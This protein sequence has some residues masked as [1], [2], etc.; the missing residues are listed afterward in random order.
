MKLTE[1]FENLIKEALLLENYNVL[2]D[3]F[4][5]SP[6]YEKMS[7]NRQVVLTVQ[8]AKRKL[9]PKIEDIVDAYMEIVRRNLPTDSASEEAYPRWRDA[10]FWIKGIRNRPILLADFIR[11]VIG[12]IDEIEVRE[13]RKK[14]EKDY[15]V[16]LKSSNLIIFKPNTVESSCR[17]G[18]GTKWCTTA[19]GSANM[20]DHY[21]KQGNLYYLSTRLPTPHEKIA[22]FVYDSPAEMFEAFDSTDSTIPSYELNSLIKGIVGRDGL[23]KIESLLNITIDS[24]KINYIEDIPPNTRVPNSKISGALAEHGVVDFAGNPNMGKAID[25]V[26]RILMGQ[27]NFYSLLT[28][29]DTDEEVIAVLT[30]N[31]R[32]FDQLLREFKSSLYLVDSGK[33]EGLRELVEVIRDMKDKGSSYSNASVWDSILYEAMNSV[34]SLMGVSMPDLDNAINDII[35]DEPDLIEQLSEDGRK[36]VSAFRVNRSFGYA[37][38]NV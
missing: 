36:F 14:A 29:Y 13:Q 37:F 17:L 20:F 27:E 33:F 24:E 2:R 23:K 15:T 28:E 8:E 16:V 26:D 4:Y 35:L 32:T 21:N 31:N 9:S 19:S 5:N 34:I 1:I 18:K 11:T 12:A 25:E 6:M 7:Q 3:V 38:R 30:K 22:I 10:G